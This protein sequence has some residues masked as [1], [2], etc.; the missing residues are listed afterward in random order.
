MDVR[1]IIGNHGEKIKWLEDQFFSKFELTKLELLKKITCGVLVYTNMH[2][3][4]PH[5]SI[6][7]ISDEFK[8]PK[9]NIALIP[10]L[11]NVKFDKDDEKEG[12]CSTFYHYIMGK[13]I[14]FINI[15]PNFTFVIGICKL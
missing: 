15:Q 8:M 10:L 1:L 13:L 3:Y 12:V 7:S 14:Y 6:T 5:S 9:C 11:K 4:V 2:L